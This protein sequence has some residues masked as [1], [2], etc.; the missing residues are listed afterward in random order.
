MSFSLQRYQGFTRVLATGAPAPLATLTIYN[1][2]GTGTLATIYADILGTPK[3]NPFTS[4]VNGYFAFYAYPDNYDIRVSGTGISPYTLGDSQVNPKPS[5]V[6]AI[7]TNVD[8][9]QTELD[10]LTTRVDNALY[11]TYNVRDYG[12]LGNLSHNDTPAFLA[13]IA[14]AKAGQGNVYVPGGIYLLTSPLILDATSVRFFGE[15]RY[16]SQLAFMTQLSGTVT[17]ANGST[18]VV[19]SGT[20]FTTQ[21]VVG[22]AIFVPNGVNDTIV[23][24]TDNTHLTLANAAPGN[25]SGLAYYR[26]G[27]RST[28][29]IQIGQTA[30]QWV[31][32]DHLSVKGDITGRVSPVPASAGAH[33]ILWAGQG[34]PAVA[35]REVS[36]VGFADHMF[37]IRGGTGPSVIEHCDLYNGQ[38]YGIFITDVTGQAPQ[39]IS[40][41]DTS[42]HNCRGGVSFEGCSSCNATDLDIELADYALKPCIHIETG[43][44]GNDTHS[45][46]VTNCSL[47][48]KGAPS[49]AAAIYV[50][51]YGNVINGGR[52]EVN[53]TTVASNIAIDT[54]GFHN[55]VI[56]G[57]YANNTTGT[58]YF[59][60]TTGA[61]LHN[62]FISPHLVMGTYAAN[63]GLVFDTTFPGAATNALGVG[64]N[65]GTITDQIYNVALSNPVASH[66]DVPSTHQVTVVIGGVTYKLLA[67]T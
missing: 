35:I 1:P 23:A 59:A 24:I 7:Q 64:N 36:F 46:N 4:D 19:G 54:N 33:A 26:Q 17:I 38:G 51:G 53:G 66:A 49:P 13:C 27:I 58:G 37:Y 55:V 32:I 8:T 50:N 12:A 43:V 52:C 56:G 21:Y 9:L 25:G 29:V 60:T 41:A 42:I 6:I 20:S 28:P 62:T 16:Q 10:A 22:D 2:V 61:A 40:I 18:T 57:V 39:D 45:I 44:N 15:N 63:R 34:E 48:T 31:E 67:T 11:K 14:A 47:S 5:E 3:S 65:S 30:Q